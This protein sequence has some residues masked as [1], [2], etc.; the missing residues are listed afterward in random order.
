MASDRPR[1]ADFKLLEHYQ[2]FSVEVARVSLLAIGGVGALY[3]L[4][5]GE[6]P[7]VLGETDIKWSFILGLGSFGA[8]IAFAL[9]HRYFATEFM[10]CQVRLDRLRTDP[11]EGLTPDEVE[12]LIKTELGSR[13]RASRRATRAVWAGPLFLALGAACLAYG[14]G[15]IVYRRT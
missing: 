12:A 6:G 5:L 11:R 15:C 8:A 1:E 9:F 13:L 3:S 10:A 4:K 7:A 14:F 2:A